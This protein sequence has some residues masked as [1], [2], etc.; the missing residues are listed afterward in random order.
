MIANEKDWYGL[1]GRNLENI[2]LIVAQFNRNELGKF[3]ILTDVKNTNGIEIS[4]ILNTTW[5]NAPDSSGIRHIP[6]WGALCDLCSESWVFDNGEAN[7]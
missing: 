4:S 1:L 6:S 2:T 7:D 3:K 5:F